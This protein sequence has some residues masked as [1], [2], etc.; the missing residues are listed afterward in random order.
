MKNKLVLS[1]IAPVVVLLVVLALPKM[2]PEALLP[3]MKLRAAAVLPP[4]TLLGH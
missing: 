2:M 3:E 1:T 4:I